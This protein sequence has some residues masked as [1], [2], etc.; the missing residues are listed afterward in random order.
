MPEQAEYLFTDAFQD[1]ILACM[2]RHPDKF[3]AVGSVVLPEYFWG[4]KSMVVC[5]VLQAYALKHGF[6][7]TFPVLAE[8]V[9]DHYGRD[10]EEKAAETCEYV[11]HLETLDTRDV[12]EVVAKTVKFARERA[13][14]NAVHEAAHRLKTDAWPPE[15]FAPMFERA[16]RVGE[17]IL[18]IGYSAMDD[19]EYV[20]DLV[21]S[22]AYGIKTRTPLDTLW[23]NGWAPGWLV[24][25]LA[26]P[27]GRKS[28]FATSLALNM[29]SKLGSEPALPVFYYTC[30]ITA[31]LTLTRAYAALTGRPMNEIYRTPEIFKHELRKTLNLAMGAPLIV[32][33][34]PAKT[35]TI[36]DIRAHAR[37]A[38][39]RLGINPR[40]I[41]IDHAETVKPAPGKNISDWR[42]QSDI[43]TQAA[44]LGSELQCVV[45]M[46]DRCTRDAVNRK[47]PNITHFQGAFEKAG[48]VDIGI[49][50]CQTPE[51]DKMGEMRFFVF[52]NRHGR[53]YVQF[54]GKVEPETMRIHVGNQIPWIPDD[55]D[56][57][58]KRVRKGDRTRGLPPEL[59]DN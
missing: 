42:Q 32:K 24:V 8:K 9:Y 44:A 10:E 23:P 12:N 4:V 36:A 45:I 14:I 15:G 1:V 41:F 59:Q 28:T 17:N 48:V 13:I 29:T 3:E 16:G 21:T 46:P 5:Q 38:A 56:P 25:P 43:Y 27:K 22:K 34:Y 52:V 58:G 49:G 47:T 26:P 33:S 40:A 30:E 2:V 57:K 19:A 39:A 7:P 6:Y 18:D 20:I 37:L 35:A 11:K 54:S 55:D 50:L 53:Q 31:E 51:E